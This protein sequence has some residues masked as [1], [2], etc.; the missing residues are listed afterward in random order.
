MR[1]PIDNV[2]TILLGAILSRAVTGASPFFPTILA[3]ALIVVLYKICS[4]LSVYSHAFGK[5]VKG[6]EK[7]IYVDG[8][9]LKESMKKCMVTEKDL[10]EELRI[11]VNL[12]S[13]EKIDRIYLERNGE[14]S[15]VLKEKKNTN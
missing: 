1:M 7:T 2:L 11:N 3:G 9:L 12:D 6:E 8:K 13:F 14:I 10:H 5:L 4:W 15:V